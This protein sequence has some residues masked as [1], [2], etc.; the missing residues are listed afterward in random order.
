LKKF[1]LIASL[2]FFISV[3]SD[4]QQTRFNSGTAVQ[5]SY[6]RLYPN[7]AT[8]VINFDFQRNYEKGYSVQIFNL[9]GKVMYEQQN[10][11]ERS[12]INLSQF[13]RGVYIYYLR[14]RNNQVIETNKF[15]VAK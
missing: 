6:V 13:S 5:A 7:P 8:T 2:V 15:Q 1:L 10:L 4:A 14:D 11:P 12:S 9:L 3:Q